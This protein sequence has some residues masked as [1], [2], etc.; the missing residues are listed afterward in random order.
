[1]V[2]TLNV[3]RLPEA[4]QQIL[5]GQF[6][7]FTCPSCQ[8]LMRIEKDFLYV[9]FARKTFIS[10]KAQGQ[11]HLWE[12][13]SKELDHGLA[14]VPTR[15]L[16]QASRHTRVVYGLSELREKLVAQDAGVDD[17]EVELLK[18][19]VVYEHPILIQK[20]RIS[21]HLH[22]V[23]EDSY[24]FVAKFDHDP[25]VFVASLPRGVLDELTHHRDRRL[26]NWVRGN[27]RRSN[28]FR[29]KNDHWINMWRWSP[30][31]WALR[32]LAEFARAICAGNDIDTTSRK[33]KIMLD[34]LP[35]GS[36]LP[37]HAKRELKIVFDHVK[38][39]GLGVL[40]DS[41]FEIRFNVDLEDDWH[42]NNDPDDIDTIWNLLKDLPDT[43]VEGNSS[44]TK[45]ELLEQSGGG[46]YNPNTGGIG[47]GANELPHQERFEDVVRHEIGHA[48]HQ[49]KKTLVDRWLRSEFGWQTLSASNVGIDDWIDM[50]GGWNAWGS[51]TSVERSEIRT[52]I[53]QYL[54]SALWHEG[55]KPTPPSSHPW[56]A[57]GFGPRKAFE[58]ALKGGRSWWV[59]HRA[60]YQVNGLAF[61]P[62]FY[63]KTLMVVSADTLKVV[64]KMPNPYASMSPPEFFA[65]L[66]AVYYDLDDPSRK[67][68]P[69]R[70]TKWL[71][72][73]IGAPEPRGA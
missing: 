61:C 13:A 50:M 36:H 2:R 64:A 65:E 21:L 54:G 68:L 18:I 1:M 26:V 72:R 28:I 15:V 48:T 9:D 6:H 32:Y 66:Y 19:L 33:F 34:F 12:D 70:V 27:H 44:L 35:R 37:S 5:D 69:S 39:K 52:F 60:W 47:I 51:T 43:N 30:Q 25:E 40:E 71:S 42:K 24:D 62:N 7:C 22:D 20:P 31:S 73:N 46:W 29:L 67:R 56:N 38:A 59:N 63:Y 8:K 14:R 17:R 11:R 23:T 41:L 4:R 57:T 45:I 53:R 49:K 55:P 16:S 58:H 3:E 10:V